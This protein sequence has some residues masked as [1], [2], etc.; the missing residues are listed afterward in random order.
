M[1]NK[2]RDVKLTLNDIIAKKLEVKNKRNKKMEYYIEAL[3]GE[4]TVTVPEDEYILKTIDMIKDGEDMVTVAEAYEYLI[5]NSVDIFRNVELH[6]AYEIEIGQ[7]IVKEL[8]T[9][10][11]R[12][13]L[14]SEIISLSGLD[15]VQERVKK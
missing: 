10:G 1:A 7:D 3:E 13:D 15:Q 14:G 8:L 12:L 11:E 6:K 9:I 4:V 2:K 5:Y